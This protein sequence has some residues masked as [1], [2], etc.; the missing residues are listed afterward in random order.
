MLFTFSVYL[1]CGAAIFK[2]FYKEEGDIEY[3]KG[4]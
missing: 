1:V 3:R 4:Q 2:E